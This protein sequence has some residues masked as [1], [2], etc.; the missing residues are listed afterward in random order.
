MLTAFM[1]E[2]PHPQSE[3]SSLVIPLMTVKLTCPC[4]S[5]V[6][7]NV[8]LRDLPAD[9]YCCYGVCGVKSLRHCS[10]F[11][12]GV[13]ITASWLRPVGGSLWLEKPALC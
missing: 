4:A 1:N 6:K 5:T 11:P 12:S 13:N 3:A 10:G 7:K 9:V 2:F 8:C